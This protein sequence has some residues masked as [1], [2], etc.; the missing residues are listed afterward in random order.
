VPDAPGTDE[1]FKTGWPEEGGRSFA[2]GLWA[3][4][5]PYN[6][7][8]NRVLRLAT[9]VTAVIVLGAIA[10]SIVLLIL[11]TRTE[12]PG[13]EAPPPPAAPAV[14]AGDNPTVVR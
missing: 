10:M 7:R 1:P 6:Y 13:F 14:P 4:V 2:R 11:S 9:Q 3:N 5:G 8:G 12:S